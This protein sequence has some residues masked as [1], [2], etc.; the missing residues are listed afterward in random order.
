[1]VTARA[2]IAIVDGASFV[3]P[4]DHGLATGLARRGYEVS[5]FGSRTRYNQ[6]FLDAMRAGA[7]AVRHAGSGD[8]AV[9]DKRA[10]DQ[11]SAANA[12]G[13]AQPALRTE[14]VDLAV[15]G[16]V[17]PRWKGVLAYAGLLFTLWRR[18]REWAR[19]NLQFSVLWPLEL[20]LFALLRSRFVFTV[21]NAVPHGFSG[22]RH[23]P[24]LWLAGLARTLVFASQA[25]HDDFM[26]RYGTRHRSKSTVLPHGLLPL[27]PGMPAL[28]Y[29]PRPAPQALVFWSTVRPYKGVE[30]FAELA[31]S[32]AWHAQG[33]ALEVVGAWSPE[34]HPLR[35][36]LLALGVTV[37]DD[38]LGATALQALLKRNVVFVL[39][40]RDASQ[41][42]ALYTLL[43]QGA[44]FLCTDVGDLGAFMRRFGLGALLLR[45]RSADA[46]IACLAHLRARPETVAAL[47]DDAQRQSQWDSTLQGAAQA[48]GAL[49]QDTP[50]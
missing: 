34:L 6:A 37:V 39:P 43:H 8:S 7:I 9:S 15:S 27:A 4:Y 40:Y 10:D 23:R 33:L 26:R 2:R 49:P 38:Y 22:Q 18:R 17:A 20:P 48:Y 36:E 45:E 5:F 50:A 35:D 44:L 11:T 32:E 21:H 29:Q 16:T 25:V 31:R 3:L 24:T 42:G 12:A 19:I 14:V 13:A 28:P 46:V 41:S 30:L 1:M 47:L